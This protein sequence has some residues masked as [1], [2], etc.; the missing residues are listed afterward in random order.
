[1]S[2]RAE[3]RLVVYTERLDEPCI[4]W[5]AER[6]EVAHCA[7][8]DGPRF[9]ELMARADGLVVRTYTRVDDALLARAPRLRVVGRAGVGLDNIDL[10]A[11]A[12]RGVEVVHTPN[13][14][15][16][17]VAEYVTALMLDALRPRA[18][19]RNAPDLATWKKTRD[20]LIAQRQL[21]DLTLGVYGLGRIG[22]SMA[23]IGAALDMR[24]IYHDL[25][26][27]PPQQRHGASP[28]S[29]ETLLREAD[30][31]TI[32]VDGRTA[33]HGLVNAAAV[34]LLKPDV[35]LINTSRGFVVDPRALG[36][37]L[38]GH[39]EARALLDVHEPEPF[40][41]DYPPLGLPNATLLPH[42]GAATR[43]AHRNMSWVVKDVWGVLETQAG[44]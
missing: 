21:S 30:I 44:T 14:N 39:P 23:R 20:A 43:A 9:G 38:R 13:A 6:C 24:V 18:G 27:I 7:S 22:K 12:A 42:L 4:A 11:C 35:V 19:L 17:A 41:P 1:M 3:R 33:N 31:L 2:D 16:R 25:L 40:G 28:V 37:F 5:L 29:R 8:E 26:E 10:R 32:H 34:A 15:T 36:A